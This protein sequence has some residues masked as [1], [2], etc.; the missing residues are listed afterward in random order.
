MMYLLLTAD[1][2]MESAL[3]ELGRCSSYKIVDSHGRVL[4]AELDATDVS[5]LS[6]AKFIFSYF[7]IASVAGIDYSRYI[8]TV[9]GCALA[10]GIP[11]GE[12]VKFE[13]FDINCKHGYSAKDIEVAVGKAME[14]HGIA[15]DL[16][17]P[18]VLA[19]SIMLN[20]R[21]YSGYVRLSDSSHGYIDPFR[22]YSKKVVSRSELKLAE[23]FDEF[24][25]ATPRTA[26]DIGAA[27]GGWSAFMARKGAAVIAIDMAMLDA[28]S[29][30]RFGLS[31]VDVHADKCAR[32]I[33]EWDR[34]KSILHIIGS[35]SSAAGCIGG[36]EADLVANDMNAGPVR[37]SQAALLFSGIMPSGAA[38]I[39]TVKCMRRNV[40]KYMEEAQAA[41]DSQFEIR[42]WKVLPHN[43]QEITLFAVKR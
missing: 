37:S 7:P 27:P 21:C 4:V 18:T 9:Q 24:G 17:R 41:L 10:I 11:A 2:F 19:Y 30:G 40:I 26:I 20:S 22:I 8:E 14:T 36:V 33:D 25:I 39:M 38:L 34:R 43:R 35:A 29:I 23:A 1:S 31:V 32:A 3:E 5:A 12:K 15:V 28:A 13:C 6:A 16:A 42:R